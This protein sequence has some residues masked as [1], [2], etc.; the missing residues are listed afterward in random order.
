MPS[1][2]KILLLN[3]NIYFYVNRYRTLFPGFSFGDMYPLGLLNL[4]SYLQKNGYEVKILDA[5]ALRFN[6]KQVISAIKEYAPDIVGLPHSLYCSF[7]A[8]LNTAKLCKKINPR[9]ITV[10]GGIWLKRYWLILTR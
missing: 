3:P 4:A 2:K 6:E 10:I 8:L 9:I 7:P 5:L 1:P